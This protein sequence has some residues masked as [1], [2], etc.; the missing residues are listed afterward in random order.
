V[1][2]GLQDTRTPLYAT[3]AS[4]A[5]N[6]V[7]NG[8]LI[9]GCGLGVKGAALGTTLSQVRAC[10]GGRGGARGGGCKFS[11]GG[12]QA[13]SLACDCCS[14]KCAGPWWDRTRPGRVRGKGTGRVRGKGKAGGGGCRVA[15]RLAGLHRVV[16]SVRLG[17]LGGGG[18]ARLPRDAAAAPA[19]V[20][21][22][23]PAWWGSRCCGGWGCRPRRRASS[24]DARSCGTEAARRG[25]ESRPSRLPTCG[26]APGS[27]GPGCSCPTRAG[28]RA[29]LRAAQARCPCQSCAE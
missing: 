5:L 29:Q 2:R 23:A 1:Y 20:G 26:E 22:Q 13:S 25:A 10:W 28:W 11:P 3:L 6:V 18:S 21:A 9:F 15:R 4:N 16:V 14:A 12:A 24:A 17:Q 7:L 27:C 19:D 8:V